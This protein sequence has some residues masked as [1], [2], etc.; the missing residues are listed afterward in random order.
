MPWPFVLAREATASACVGS[1]RARL[2]P[3]HAPTTPPLVIPTRERSE[4]GGTCCPQRRHN[5]CRDSRPRLPSQAPRLVWGRALS[6]V[7]AAQPYRAA[8]AP[9]PG[10]ATAPPTP[11]PTTPL[12]VIPTREQSETGGTCC[13]QRRHNSCGD[14]RPRLSMR[15]RC[16][17]PLPPRHTILAAPGR[18][19][20]PQ[21][22]C[23]ETTRTS[24]PLVK[25][26]ITS[27]GDAGAR[28][29]AAY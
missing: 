9:M 24:A 16:I 12:L 23:H 20:W 6:P 13:R 15:P 27:S 7:Q 3:C 14:T 19:R 5:S 21:S 29:C 28:A 1:G 2:H 11:Q 8:A 25:M 17:G 10:K 4:T 18:R 26:T 22:P